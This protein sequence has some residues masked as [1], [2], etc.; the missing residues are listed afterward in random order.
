MWNSDD[1]S[2]DNFYYVLLDDSYVSDKSNL[3]LYN[4]EMG[5]LK[6]NILGIYGSD[7]SYHYVYE[8]LPIIAIKTEREISLLEISS[9]VNVLNIKEDSFFNKTDMDSYNLIKLPDVA[10]AG[11]NSVGINIAVIDDGMVAYNNPVFGNCSS[12]SSSNCRLEIVDCLNTSSCTII[13]RSLG[14]KHG[15]NVSAIAAGIAKDSKI[16]NIIGLKSS[17]VTSFSYVLKGIDWVISNRNSKKIEVLNMSLGGDYAYTGDYCDSTNPTFYASLNILKNNDI[18]AV[19][20][21]GNNANKSSLLLPACMSNVI[22]VGAVYSKDIIGTSSFSKC[23]DLNA[24]KD[25]VTCFSN[26]SKNLDILA[27]G[28]FIEGAGI[29][30]AGT[31]QASPHVAGAYAVLKSKFPDKSRQEIENMLIDGGDYIRDINL[32]YKPRLNILNSIAVGNGSFRKKDYLPPKAN[33]LI[34]SYVNTTKPTFAISYEDE[35]R[36]DKMC[37]QTSPDIN[38]CKNKWQVFKESNQIYIS[39]A[40]GTKN[41]YLWLIDEFGN[42]NDQPFTK[43]F[44]YDSISPRMNNITVKFNKTDNSALLLWDDAI[45]SNLVSYRIYYSESSVFNFNNKCNNDYFL[46][47]GEITADKNSYKINN[48]ILGRKYSFMVCSIDPSGNKTVKNISNL[49]FK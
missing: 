42:K 35:S 15:T 46:H 44:I 13:N 6:K 5:L 30:M 11:Y 29:S 12:F 23:Y 19:V 40:Q 48:L 26:S 16:Y 43:T 31:S 4:D 45:D 25:Q 34:N 21:A 37:F 1:F 8:N 9:D 39:S 17:G 7:L 3:K 38:L 14:G 20:A 36:I 47:N 49:L 28:A 2:P 27:P 18:A 10:L 32:I 22:S 33:I 41:I 24:K